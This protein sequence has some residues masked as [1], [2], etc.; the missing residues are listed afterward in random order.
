MTNKHDRNITTRPADDQAE[1][2]CPGIFGRSPPQQPSAV[3]PSS[4]LSS[5][6]ATCV[7]SLVGRLP[8][9]IPSPS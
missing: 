9:Q 7:G 3:E 4:S 8:P 2:N 1:R 6:P 5:Y